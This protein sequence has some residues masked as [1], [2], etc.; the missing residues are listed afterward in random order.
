[1]RVAVGIGEHAP[2]IGGGHTFV[3]GV[4]DALLALAKQSPHQFTVLCEPEQAAQLAGRC[5]SAGV[6]CRTLPGSPLLGKAISA[7]RLY[8]PLGGRF[9]HWPVRVERAAR[10]A[11]AQMI[12]FVCGGVP[13][14]PLDLPYVATV[15]DLQHRT[16]PW[17]PEVS[18]MG[19]WYMREVKHANFLRRAAR[20]I[21][22]TKVG[23][24][25]LELIYGIP[26]ER[27]VILPHPT[28]VLG[29]EPIAGSSA[30]V[31]RLAGSRFFFYPAQFWPH[32]NHVN[33]LHAMKLL[34]DRDSAAPGL[35]LT[36]ADQGNLKHVKA[37][38]QQ[39]GLQDRVHFPGFV[40]AGDLAW[41]YRNAL[42]LAY[43]SFS[44]PENLP[45]LEAFSLGC[46]VAMADYPGA[47][48]QAG[49]AA[50]FFDPAEPAQIAD[51]LGQIAGQAGLRESLVER[52]RARAARWTAQ[53]YVKGVFAML[54]NF[55]KIRRC[56]D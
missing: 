50:I 49:D 22:G 28:P 26:A 16:H 15:W 7:L 31:A 10:S 51:A 33:L 2:E 3:A 43:A 14:A 8:T 12:W 23:A 27:I 44:G 41:L 30:M 36:G 35:V 34:G 18:A 45:P 19:Q 54:D 47:R 13:A 52:G 20:V 39:L 21:A 55:E 11:G 46:P 25:Q 42:A 9:I 48:E 37:V 17:F 6:Q 29:A 40:G 1:M 32:K 38:A 53:D 56:W 5:A 24:G 4:V